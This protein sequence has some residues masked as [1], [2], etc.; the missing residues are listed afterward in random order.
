MRGRLFTF[1]LIGISVVEYA[2]GLCPFNPR[3]LT[4]NSIVLDAAHAAHA[5]LLE[6][7]Q[8]SGR[9]PCNSC[10]SS[11]QSVLQGNVYVII[12]VLVY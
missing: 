6:D 8:K 10:Y 2:D 5:L 1:C 9:S 4:L 7:F 3:A 12:L 11:N